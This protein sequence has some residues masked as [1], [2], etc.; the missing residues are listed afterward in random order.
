MRES[1]QAK[2]AK[3]AKRSKRG[4]NETIDPPVAFASAA[5]AVA[6]VLRGGGDQRGVRGGAGSANAKQAKGAKK[7]NSQ[8]AKA[9]AET[10]ALMKLMLKDLCSI[11]QAAVILGVK[12]HQV[13]VLIGKKRI[14]A[15]QLEGSRI[16]IVHKPSLETYLTTKSK[17]GRPSGSKHRTKLLLDN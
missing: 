11:S 2:N 3:D 14:A 13:H 10:E 12:R 4:E 6:A 8:S 7:P 16:W 17:R 15:V 1:K 5:V 9:Q